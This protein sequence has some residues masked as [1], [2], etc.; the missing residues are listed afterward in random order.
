[1]KHTTLFL[2]FLFILS[3]THL[4]AQQGMRDGFM[5]YASFET[6]QQQLLD[7]YP[8][9][10]NEQLFPSRSIERRWT[11]AV[12]V[13]LGVMS[14]FDDTPFFTSVDLGVFSYLIPEDPLEGGH[15]QLENN[16]GLKNRI[17][18]DHDQMSLGFS[19]G[20]RVPRASDFNV[21]LKPG[22]RW[23]VNLGQNVRYNSNQ[24]QFDLDVRQSLEDGT[25]QRN[26]FSVGG[27]LG[28]GMLFGNWDVSLSGSIYRGLVD[29]LRTEPNP[30]LWQELPS[31]KLH[32]W[33]ISLTIGYLLD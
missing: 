8:M 25:T 22:F 23:D 19:F 1:M 18:F 12:G 15:F 9:L 6:Q 32:S 28:A 33:G 11:T 27:S 10:Y 20:V 26:N 29:V 2:L 24:P 5:A 3:N 17:F 21:I 31:N 7:I 4:F 14:T 13:R 16:Q 30:F